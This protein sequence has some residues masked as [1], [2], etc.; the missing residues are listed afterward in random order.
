MPVKSRHFLLNAQVAPRVLLLR[1]I[2]KITFPAAPVLETW[3]GLM[4]QWNTG[5]RAV[6]NPV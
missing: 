4:R 2:G 3:F 5:A 1:Q 6:G